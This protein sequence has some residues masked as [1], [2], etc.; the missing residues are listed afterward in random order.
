MLV[1][2]KHLSEAE[3]RKAAK[4]AVTD[5]T[6]W[7]TKHPN[8]RV[9]RVEG[10]YGV[11]IHVHRKSVAQ[12]IDKAAETAIQKDTRLPKGTSS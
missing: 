7:F 1:I 11:M 12:D 6:R 10:W 9:C 4:T 2:Y 3:I 8:R 5:V